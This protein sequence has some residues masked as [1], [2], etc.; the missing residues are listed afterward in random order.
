MQCC[1]PWICGEN[2]C[3]CT[4]KHEQNDKR[5]AL[6]RRN[7][8]RMTMDK[9]PCLIC[10]QWQVLVCGNRKAVSMQSPWTWI[11]E[12]NAASLYADI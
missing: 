11:Y 8:N 9:S 5:H 3:P 1:C 4:W 6:V 12:E 2:G 7:V 10:E